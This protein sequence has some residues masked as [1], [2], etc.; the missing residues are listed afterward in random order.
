MVKSAFR[1]ALV[2]VALLLS[3]ISAM[4]Q[5][6]AVVTWS[7]FIKNRHDLTALNEQKRKKI[8][9]ELGA[10]IV[11]DP[12]GVSDEIERSSGARALCQYVR[13][14]FASD[15]AAEVVDQLDAVL[16][17]G[18]RDK[19]IQ[20]RLGTPTFDDGSAWLPRAKRA[21]YFTGCVAGTLDGR[22]KGGPNLAGRLALLLKARDQTIVALQIAERLKI[23]PLP[24]GD[25][26]GK[27]ILDGLAKKELLSDDALD[28]FEL[29]FDRSY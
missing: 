18:K 6:Q 5:N 23:G 20:E 11:A 22:R 1:P 13:L 7:D 14:M 4:G 2:A 12:A 27:W 24:K 10:A 3:A 9:S 28:W 25:S 17:W 16:H 29:G 21:G 19:S 8:L 26:Y 15:R